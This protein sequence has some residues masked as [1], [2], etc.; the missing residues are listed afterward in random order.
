M[1]LNQPDSGLGFAS[2]ATM[3]SPLGPHCAP[4]VPDSTV[5]LPQA[6]TTLSVTFP[7]S[8]VKPKLDVHHK[9]CYDSTNHIHMMCCG[10][11]YAFCYT[12]THTQTHTQFI[13]LSTTLV[14]S[15]QTEPCHLQLPCCPITTDPQSNHTQPL[16]TPPPKNS[17]GNPC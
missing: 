10:R 15:F 6:P 16:S 14:P 9:W 4:A 8:I 3:F 2:T 17:P 11:T 1:P 13:P 5:P 7:I 12:H